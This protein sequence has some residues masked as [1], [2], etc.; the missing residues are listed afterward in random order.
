MVE[1]NPDTRRRAWIER[2]V[3]LVIAVVIAIL[4]GKRAYF[5]PDR[6]EALHL[7][8]LAK[9]FYAGL[10]WW[11]LLA[12]WRLV[13]AI[14]NRR[15]HPLTTN[16]GLPISFTLFAAYF[17]FWL[18]GMWPGL[19]MGDSF[20]VFQMVQRLWIHAWYSY[21]HTLLHI[22]LYQF[23][24]HVMVVGVFQVV[25]AACVLGWVG[26]QLYPRHKVA[27]IVFHV[28]VMA[29]LATAASVISYTVDIV[30]SLLYLSIAFWVFD[31]AMTRQT[32]PRRSAPIA[33][34]ILMGF[35]ANYRG[36]AVFLAPV[37][38]VVMLMFRLR[39]LRAVAVTALI[40]F[41]TYIF[42]AYPLRT[43]VFSLS[44]TTELVAKQKYSY[45]MTTRL[46]PLG[47]VLT[48]P[49][50]ARD[51]ERQEA[52]LARVINVQ[53]AKEISTPFETNI[54]LQEYWNHEMTA[55]DFAHFDRAVK[56]LV[57]DNLPLVLSGRLLTFLSSF[58]IS[59]NTTFYFHDFARND[60][61]TRAMCNAAC[62]Q[63]VPR[64]PIFPNV[65]RKLLGLL[66]RSIEFHG[67]EL[68]G[69]FLHW[70]LL[71]ALFLVMAACAA[72]GALP[73]T[74]AA[75]LVVFAREAHPDPR[76]PSSA[77]QIPSRALSLWLHRPVPR[78]DRVA[79]PT[80]F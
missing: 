16:I 25:L 12:G 34:A 19:V 54:W 17:G 7:L 60:H 18:I 2:I 26:G 14:R 51:R 63:A 10:V 21:V 53:K 33:L 79:S 24:P 31:A 8:T 68:R 37:I 40:F 71:P 70:N 67:A 35:L 15:P 47:A 5:T 64:D 50:Y 75:S 72:Y 80:N 62:S 28:G 61:P 30:F 56:E 45:L 77:V 55:D 73:A 42:F 32:R 41:V 27:F 66:D 4:S 69:R 23:Y 59:P 9:V 46:N 39:P 58:G 57:V 13:D 22:V 78:V 6:P 44:G 76:C 74:A 52:D 43:A 3:T 29:S 49:H 48:Q 20:G 36:E 1:V 38:L 65:Y 11:L